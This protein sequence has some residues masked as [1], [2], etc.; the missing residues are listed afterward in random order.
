MDIEPYHLGLRNLGNQVHQDPT[1]HMSYLTQN[2]YYLKR[3]MISSFDLPQYVYIYGSK[4]SFI[5]FIRTR[6]M[7]AGFA[8]TPA[9]FPLHAPWCLIISITGARKIGFSIPLEWKFTSIAA[10]GETYLIYV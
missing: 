6:R 8:V 7:S 9:T 10:V 4:L 5:M 3:S 2:K 1:N